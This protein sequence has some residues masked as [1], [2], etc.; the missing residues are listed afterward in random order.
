MKYVALLP[1]LVLAACGG[2]DADTTGPPAGPSTGSIL[3]SVTTTGS[4]LDSDGYSV[5]M[6]GAAAAT[7]GSNGTVTLSDVSTGH[8]SVSLA[9]VAANCTVTTEHPYTTNVTAGNTVQVSFAINCQSVAG[10]LEVT[11]TTTGFDLDPDGYAVVL[12][13]GES[14]ALAAN[15]SVTFPGIETGPHQLLLTGTADNCTVSGANPRSASVTPT[16]VAQVAFS[17]IC[18]MPLFNHIA[19]TSDRDGNQYDIFVMEADGSNPFNVTNHGA[20]DRQPS[21]SPDGARIAFES[22]RNGGNWDIYSIDAGG[23][24]LVLL[25]HNTA[26]SSDD[27]AAWSPDG[28]HIAFTSDRDGNEEIYVM[29]ADG[30]NPVNLTNHAR[31]DRL[32]AW[33]PDGTHIAFASVRDDNY[34]I[35]VMNADGS[36]PVNLTNYLSADT[37]PAWSP[38]GTRIAFIR[39]RDDNYQ[40]IYVMDSDGSNLTRLTD[41]A[42]MKEWPRWS[43]DGTHIAFHTN[44]DGNVE[45]YVMEADGSNPVNLTNNPFN[46]W[47]PAWS[48]RE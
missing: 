1:L 27:R 3:V 34:E 42:D 23:S 32:P 2:S 7:V 10:V 20:F 16:S 41:S 5:H 25:T 4:D 11:T 22:D 38:D 15:D 44:R 39:Y 8:R 19:F 29:N 35:Y 9:G 17:V 46:D 36:N 18:T 24:N 31:F 37:Y 48:P 28:T 21:W 33:S 14:H 40:D 13:G 6:D 26:G 30:S 43:P 47:D 45:I 12:D